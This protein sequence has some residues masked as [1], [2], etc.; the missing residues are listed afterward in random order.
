[1]DGGPKHFAHPLLRCVNRVGF[2]EEHPG[3]EL[4][5]LQ[6]AGM[7]GSIIIRCAIMQ[8][9]TWNVS[10]ICIFF[11]SCQMCQIITKRVNQ[12]IKKKIDCKGYKQETD[13]F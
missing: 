5:L 9:S 13:W 12:E 7:A 11:P 2:E 4:V 10:R 3:L 8:V 6:N 1:M